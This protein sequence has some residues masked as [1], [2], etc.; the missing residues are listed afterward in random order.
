MIM[1]QQFILKKHYI[2]WLKFIIRLVL[3]DE[4]KKYANLLGYNYQSGLNGM[5]NHIKFLIKIMKKK[6]SA[7]KR[8]KRL[9]KKK[10]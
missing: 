9:L 10:I 3:K 4:A 5:K 8:K 1:I 6:N 7:K 2:D